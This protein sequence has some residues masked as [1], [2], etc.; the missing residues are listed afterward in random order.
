MGIKTLDSS[1]SA[2]FSN[3][4]ATEKFHYVPSMVL[5]SY[6]L[7]R[8]IVFAGAVENVPT[9]PLVMVRTHEAKLDTGLGSS[10]S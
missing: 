2:V 4:E 10:R 7:T 9:L 1:S 6:G 8:R 3:H 5:L